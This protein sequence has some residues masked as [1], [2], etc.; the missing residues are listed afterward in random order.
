MEKT[1]ALC[2]G[3]PGAISVCSEVF[4]KYPQDTLAFL[5]FCTE[6]GIT[7]SAVWAWF[8]HQCGQDITSLI[9]SFHEIQ[10]DENIKFRRGDQKLLDYLRSQAN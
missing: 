5:D 1:F 7:G 4:A 2:S 10:K 3:I 8:K 9:D 6:K